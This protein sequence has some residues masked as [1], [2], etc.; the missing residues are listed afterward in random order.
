MLRAC[1]ALGNTT[2]G[3]WAEIQSY[4]RPSGDKPPEADYTAIK[5]DGVWIIVD[6]DRNPVSIMAL[7]RDG[8]AVRCF[9]DLS[10]AW[11]HIDK[12]R[13]VWY[14]SKRTRSGV[15]YAHITA[16]GAAPDKGTLTWPKRSKA[17]A[18][19]RKTSVSRIVKCTWLGEL[20]YI[21]LGHSVS[22][23]SPPKGK[24]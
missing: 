12:L 24:N 6:R 8:N 19:M 13:G 11:A 16:A 21:I 17:T 3:E 7:D 15:F 9:D 4:I 18:H 2:A 23:S 10:N 1:Y 20:S 5:R 14:A 22:H